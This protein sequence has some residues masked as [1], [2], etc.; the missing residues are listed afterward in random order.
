MMFDRPDSDVRRSP[1]VKR[2]DLSREDGTQQGALVFCIALI[3]GMILAATIAPL[4]LTSF[5]VWFTLLMLS[6]SL[7]AGVRALFA[8][9]DKETDT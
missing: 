9:P 3:G 2:P 6:V 7:A 1:V 5:W 4:A 8:D